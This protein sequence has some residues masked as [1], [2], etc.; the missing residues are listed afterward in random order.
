MDRTHNPTLSPIYLISNIFYEKYNSTGFQVEVMYF[1]R[2]PQEGVESYLKKI[3]VCKTVNPCMSI[4]PAC[5]ERQR[6]H[7]EKWRTTPELPVL[8]GLRTALSALRGLA[9]PRHTDYSVDFPSVFYFY[10]VKEP[11]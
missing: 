3:N 10:I 5:S 2:E 7:R 8:P 6:C 9:A 11:A 1:S 4:Y